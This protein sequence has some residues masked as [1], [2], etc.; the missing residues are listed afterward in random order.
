MTVI[1]RAAQ[2]VLGGTMALLLT[3]GGAA[4]SATAA[5]RKDTNKATHVAATVVAQPSSGN[6]LIYDISTVNYGSDIAFYTNVTIPLDPAKLQ[7]TTTELSGAASWLPTNTPNLIELRTERLYPNERAT[8]RLTLTKLTADAAL[9][10]PLAFKWNDV[11]NNHGSTNTPQ[12]Y[13]A[14]YPLAAATSGAT[15]SFATTLFAP[16]EPVTLWYNTPDGTAVPI[17]VIHNGEVVT[18][19]T[20]DDDTKKAKDYVTAS[21]GA[22]QISFATGSLPAGNYLLVARGN[23]SS[24]TA[25]S[26]FQVP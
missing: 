24:L 7:V 12:L 4:G 22:I 3:F 25:T 21:D 10:N 13:Q 5:S 18:A 9:T 11:T 14:T 26:A 15:T 20:G 2:L 16:D 17:E 8:L 6:T 1:G 23:W 19:A